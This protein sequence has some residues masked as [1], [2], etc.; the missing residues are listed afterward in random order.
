MDASTPEPELGVA[1]GAKVVKNV[2]LVTIDT[3]RADA[4]HLFGGP[5]RM[6]ALESLAASG[7]SF[8]ECISASMLT[9]P[10]HV[11]IFTSLYPREH[12]VYDNESGVQDGARTL[13]TE[14]LRGGF[15]TGAVVNF[16]H[17]NPDT[18]NLGQGFEH[19]VRA[20]RKERSAPEVAKLGLAWLDEVKDGERFFL[21]LHMTEPHAPYE[22]PAD[23]PLVALPKKT[24]MQ[25]ALR[26]APRFQKN[27]EWFARAFAEYG[28][29]EELVQRYYAEIAAADRGLATLVSGLEAR[30]LYEDT[31]LVVTSDHGENLGEHE[32][33]FHHG[34]LYRETVHVPL[35]VRAPGRM[36]V[37]SAEL[38]QTVDIAPT[39]MD[40]VGL[41]PWQPMRGLD[42]AKVVAPGGH[43]HP[44]AY[45]EHMY[46][47]LV[48]V[49]N[50]AGT[51]VVHQKNSRQFP[52]YPFSAGRRELYRLQDDGHEHAVLPPSGPLADELGDA[53][54]QFLGGDVSLLAKRAA[55][56]DKE[57]LRAL[58]YIE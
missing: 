30:G 37:K 46:G 1:P 45:S 12:G 19:F 27:N 58:G 25:K 43:G 16:P 14:L 4:L 57:S 35:V 41:P 8:A 36:P 11:S 13:A 31:L 34:G 32:L 56:P 49:R 50:E 39:V 51:L 42:L 48:S 6:P 52:T 26:A 44:Y 17:L 21:W 5:V 18:A 9:N 24:P 7:W 38:V 53:L 55:A 15:R 54:S 22:P 40:L 3:L 33:Y 2:V 10:S 29:T 28:Y 23:V 47:Q 20:T